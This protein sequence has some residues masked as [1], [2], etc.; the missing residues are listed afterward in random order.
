MMGRNESSQTDKSSYP[1]IWQNGSFRNREI[2]ETAVFQQT[3]F[4]RVCSLGLMESATILKPLALA[5]IV[6]FCFPSEPNIP[7]G[8]E[9]EKNINTIS[10]HEEKF[11]QFYTETTTAVVTPK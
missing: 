6:V 10:M 11:Y 8:P 3:R 7:E 1:L 9:Y 5:L 4:Y 2:V